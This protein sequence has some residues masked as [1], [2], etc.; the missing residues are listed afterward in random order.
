MK[1]YISKEI[2]KQGEA[3]HHFEIETINGNHNQFKYTTEF[4]ITS[5]CKHLMTFLVGQAMMLP[6]ETEFSI[7]D[8]LDM[9]GDDIYGDIYDDEIYAINTLLERYFE[10]CFTLVKLREGEAENI[11]VKVFKR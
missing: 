4:T 5:K 3:I 7:D 8:L 6:N 1:T 11:I 10:E 2:Y 9:V